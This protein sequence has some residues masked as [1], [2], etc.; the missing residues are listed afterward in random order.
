[1]TD[2]NETAQPAPLGQVERGV[3]RLAPKRAYVRKP[4]PNPAKGERCPLCGGS[5]VCLQSWRKKA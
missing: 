5:F 2:R 3:G 1:M 4:C